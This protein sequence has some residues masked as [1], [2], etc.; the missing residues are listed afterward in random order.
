MAPRRGGSHDEQ[1]E[2]KARSTPGCALRHAP[3]P[4]RY[5]GRCGLLL[6]PFS[7]MHGHSWYLIALIQGMA[8][9]YKVP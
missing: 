2:G 7:R 3:Y 4:Q 5:V 1:D 9:D 8:L 6:T